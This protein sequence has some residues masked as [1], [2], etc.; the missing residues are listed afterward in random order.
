MSRGNLVTFKDSLKALFISR[1][2]LIKKGEEVNFISD[3]GVALYGDVLEE[4]CKTISEIKQKFPE[5]VNKCALFASVENELWREEFKKNFYKIFIDRLYCKSDGDVPH[6]QFNK[7]SLEG[8]SQGAD[9]CYAE[10]F[11]LGFLEMLSEVQKQFEKADAANIAEKDFLNLLINFNKIVTGSED[12]IV[13][14]VGRSFGAV[15]TYQDIARRKA[16]Q[17]KYGGN[18]IYYDF[19]SCEFVT[20][21][22]ENFDH[23]A[24]CSLNYKEY[25]N[26]LKFG[27]NGEDAVFKMTVL[28]PSCAHLCVDGNAR[29]ANLFGWMAAILH[30]TNYPIIMTPKN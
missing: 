24:S 19:T 25:L 7:T 4:I 23:P 13:A 26:A 10:G 1:L 17:N 11:A 3:G 27:T 21:L 28:I 16:A 30:N 12:N 6:L 15:A 14:N 20:E 29:S 9:L 18:Q 8:N 2:N 5:K 22:D